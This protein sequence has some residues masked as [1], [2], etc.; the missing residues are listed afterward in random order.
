MTMA[1]NVRR[2]STSR[3]RRWALR[4]D[5]MPAWAF[6]LPSLRDLRLAVGAELIR[7]DVLE[8]V[9]ADEVEGG[10]ACAAPEGMH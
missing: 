2:L 10:H 8:I 3:L 1:V 4:F 9:G 7:R 5:S 6:L